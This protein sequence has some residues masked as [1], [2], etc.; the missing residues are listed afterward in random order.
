MMTS[1]LCYFLCSYVGEKLRNH[2]NVRD[3][4][5]CACLQL[6][7]CLIRLLLV[8]VQESNHAKMR[9]FAVFVT[10]LGEFHHFIFTVCTYYLKSVGGLSMHFYCYVAMPYLVT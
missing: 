2:A 7:A 3:V 8:Q 1:L 5:Q 6:K 4:L 10:K 9:C